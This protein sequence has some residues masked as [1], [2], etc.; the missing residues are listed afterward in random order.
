M[1]HQNNH[2]DRAV[3]QRTERLRVLSAIEDAVD[4]GIG[5]L[6]LP[7][8]MH[9]R[10]PSSRL[11]SINPS[12]PPTGTPSTRLPTASAPSTS[13]PTSGM[14]SSGTP[15]TGLPT[16][17]PTGS[18]TDS[19]TRARTGLS[20]A[21]TVVPP[22][23]PR[24]FPTAPEARST[25]PLGY[26]KRLPMPSIKLGP[27]GPALWWPQKQ[28]PLYLKHNLILETE[29]NDPSF[30]RDAIVTKS[31]RKWLY[32]LTNQQR[33][34]AVISCAVAFERFMKGRFP[35]GD[36][37]LEGGSLIG[38]LRA[39]HRFIPWD[40][41]ADVT[42]LEASWKEVVEMLM[43]EDHGDPQPNAEGAPCGC[44]LVDTASFG[45]AR[46]GYG[47]MNQIP[48][49]VINECTG[50][51][52]DIFNARPTERFGLVLSQQPDWLDENE[53]KS[54]WNRMVVLPPKPCKLEG[55]PFKCPAQPWR[56]LDAY[57]YGVQASEPDQVW[58]PRLHRYEPR[59]EL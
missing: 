2:E 10:R 17:S 47:K 39:P 7:A 11:P 25:G 41:D 26:W 24:L 45:S 19:P 38:A 44:L 53:A 32:E 52:V 18:R 29:T 9:T 59:L 1:I 35:K 5:D 22:Y 40:N 42:M 13:T 28:A 34:E 37:W 14:P 31:M 23:D 43:R 33:R 15:S 50:N 6:G 48:G 54:R 21:L 58:D 30:N 49:R 46:L 51:Y 27:D 56:Y 36:W 20:P 55:Y 57:S 12:T 4:H 3:A 16:T 8:D